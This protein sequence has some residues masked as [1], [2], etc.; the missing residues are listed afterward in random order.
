MRARLSVVT[1]F[2]PALAL[3]AGDVR[4]RRILTRVAIE[5][6]IAA[7]AELEAAMAAADAPAED[8][9]LLVEHDRLGGGRAQ[10]DADAVPHRAPPRF[11]SII[12]K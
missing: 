2:V 9:A 10:V 11:C 1:A 5:N 7:V 12:W 8:A 3:V 4:P 6:A